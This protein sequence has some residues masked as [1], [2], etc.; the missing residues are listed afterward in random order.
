M[1]KRTEEFKSYLKHINT[2]GQNKLYNLLSRIDELS[3]EQFNDYVA[4][5]D[6]LLFKQESE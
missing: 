6:G 4:F 2:D 3:S 1:D 5:L